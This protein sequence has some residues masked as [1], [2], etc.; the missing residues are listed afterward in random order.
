MSRLLS[1]SLKALAVVAT[2]GLLAATFAGC[3]NTSAGGPTTKPAVSAAKGS[4]E[5][6]STTCSRC[7]GLRSPSM[8]SSDQW[9]VIVHDMRIRA[10]LTT[11]EQKQITDFLV[12]ATR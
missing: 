6:W 4:A 11:Q 2:A 1:H 9:E 10:N 3:A 12:S 8:Y 5:L 7:H